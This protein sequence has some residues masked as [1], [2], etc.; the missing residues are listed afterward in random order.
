MYITN[1][2]N[3]KSNQTSL[4]PQ[5]IFSGANGQFNAFLRAYKFCKGAVYACKDRIKI[6]TIHKYMY[7]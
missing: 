6:H 5:E 4:R 7:M 1:F 2:V 3:G